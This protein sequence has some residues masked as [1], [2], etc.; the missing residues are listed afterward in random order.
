M[1]YYEYIPFQYL[2][3]TY[4]HNSYHTIIQWRIQ[5][6][7]LG[8]GGAPT[9]WGAPTSDMYTFRQKRMRKRKKLILLGGRAPAAP[10]LDPPMTISQRFYCPD[11]GEN[12]RAYITGCH[13]RQMFKKGKDFKDVP[14]SSLLRVWGNTR[15][16]F[17]KHFL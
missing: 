17:E 13:A 1:C 15:E 6:F 9:H 2:G 3:R 14:L 4:R 12:L 5:D 11:L 8:G 7:P 16:S 10:P